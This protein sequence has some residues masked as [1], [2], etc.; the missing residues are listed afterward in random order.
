MPSECLIKT[1][2]LVIGDPPSSG[3]IQ[4]IITSSLTASKLVTGAAGFAGTY[5]A[6][7]VTVLEKKLNP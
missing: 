4:V 7:I 1:V 6:K 5:A 2:K 3:A